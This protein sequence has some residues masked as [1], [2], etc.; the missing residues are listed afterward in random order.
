MFNIQ[1]GLAWC[2]TELDAKL[3]RWAVD[4]SSLS[5]FFPFSKSLEGRKKTCGQSSRLSPW[6]RISNLQHSFHLIIFD[7]ELVSWHSRQHQGASRAQN[8]ARVRTEST[9]WPGNLK[10][11]LVLCVIRCY[12]VFLRRIWDGL[13]SSLLCLGYTTYWHWR[14]SRAAAL[15]QS[16]LFETAW[17]ACIYTYFILFHPFSSFSCFAAL[18][19]S[20]PL[21]DSSRRC[22]QTGVDLGTGTEAWT[23]KA[24]QN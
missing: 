15:V 23:C 20:E 18:L 9:Q 10:K 6:F 14:D 17:D 16:L 4:G 11:Q 2:F 12:L 1:G 21:P 3:Q 24:N 19:H 8:K 22:T 13:S 7:L 5:S